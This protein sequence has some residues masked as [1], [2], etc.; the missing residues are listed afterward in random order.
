MVEGRLYNDVN[1]NNQWDAR[2]D[3]PYAREPIVLFLVPPTAAAKLGR[4]SSPRSALATTVTDSLGLFVFSLPNVSTIVPGAN[5]GIATQAE[6]D[7]VKSFAADES[8][9]V[10]YMD[11]PVV[12]IKTA[13]HTHTKTVRQVQKVKGCLTGWLAYIFYISCKHYRTLLFLHPT[14]EPRP[15]QTLRSR[16]WLQQKPRPFRSLRSP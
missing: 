14:S 15:H 1:R 13:S 12:G 8:G 3:I 2:I 16:R 5:V 4:R 7:L 6:P 9:V 11:T 10:T